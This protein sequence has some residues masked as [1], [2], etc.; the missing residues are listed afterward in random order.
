ML[1]F[2]CRGVFDPGQ[3]SRNHVAVLKR[4]DKLRTLVWIVTQPVQQLGESP[5]G[6]VHTAAPLD[7]VQLLEARQLGDERGFLLGAMVAPQVVI[8]E[9]LHAFADWN[10]AGASCIE[11]DRF[12]LVAADFSGDH[13]APRGFREGAHVIFMRLRRKIRILALAMQSIFSDGGS[14]K[15][16][17]AVD[18]RYPHAEGAEIY[19]CDDGHAK[20]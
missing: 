20:S 17:L 4:A 15:P 14:E 8:V 2:T 13:G 10:D 1:R 16:A 18:D 9:R 7:R 11:R 5:L 12:D 6:R 19:S 3:R